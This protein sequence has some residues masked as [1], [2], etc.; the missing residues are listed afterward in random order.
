MSQ[1]QV[2]KSYITIVELL[3]DRGYI[4]KSVKLP[5]DE[6]DKKY[7]MC[8]QPKIQYMCK[9]VYI[10]D[11]GQKGGVLWPKQE[12]IGVGELT[13]YTKIAMNN[14]WKSCILVVSE[15]LTTQAKK[16][17]EEHLSHL[18]GIEY[19][20]L[21]KLQINITKHRLVPQHSRLTDEEKENIIKTFKVEPMNFPQIEV[22]DPI[23]KYYKFKIGDMIRIQRK[24]VVDDN[25]IEPTFREISYRYVVEAS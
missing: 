9:V 25:E 3:N 22:T 20:T 7:S 14:E 4:T 8:K 21:N 24:T 5:F 13:Y 15:S 19:F 17:V 1:Q 6:W 10:D 11:K 16:E 12:K 18:Y 2:Y 23:S